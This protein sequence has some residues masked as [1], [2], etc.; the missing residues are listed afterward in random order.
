MREVLS[1]KQAERVAYLWGAARIKIRSGRDAR[2]MI[3]VLHRGKS[4]AMEIF[5]ATCQA[6]EILSLKR[7]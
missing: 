2:H 3:T 6:H 1:L 7:D 5:L 4:E